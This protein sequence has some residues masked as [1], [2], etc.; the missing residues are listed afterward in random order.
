MVNPKDSIKY[1]SVISRKYRF[2]YKDM[3]QYLSNF[4]N[5]VMKLKVTIKGPLFYSLNNVPMDE[6]MNVEFFMPVDEDYVNVPEDMHFHSYFFIDKMISTCDLAD[7]EAST[8]TA[9]GELLHYMESHYLRQTTP[10]Y[11]IVSGDRS[12]PYLFIK[13]GFSPQSME[14]I[15]L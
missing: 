8:E 4:M 11:H 6:I 5:D 15:W 3:E 2:Y 7:H 14:E 9:Y 13:I 12:L 1:T 10:I